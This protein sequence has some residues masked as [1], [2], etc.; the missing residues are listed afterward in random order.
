M[1]HENCLDQVGEGRTNILTR[2]EMDGAQGRQAVAGLGAGSLSG[3]APILAALLEGVGAA[4]GLGIGQ[5][6]SGQ[7]GLVGTDGRGLPILSCV[8]EITQPQ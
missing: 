2:R 3:S 4:L 5:R 1:A 8:V 7:V 6:D